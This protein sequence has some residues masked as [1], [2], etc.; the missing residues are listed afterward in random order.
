MKMK[1]IVLADLGLL[2]AVSLAAAGQTEPAKS[3]DIALCNGELTVVLG[4]HPSPAE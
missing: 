1:N 3:T 2:S 4:A